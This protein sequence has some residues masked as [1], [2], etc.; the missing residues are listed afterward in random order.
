MKTNAKL[1]TTLILDC[2]ERDVTRVA[3]VRGDDIT[4]LEENARAQEVQTLTKKLLKAQKVSLTQLDRIA[5]AVQPG[6]LTGV[7][8]GV[9]AANTMAWLLQK[10][11]VELTEPKFEAA[12]GQLL[13]TKTERKLA[14]VRD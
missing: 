6:S 5:V 11:I 1:V 14:R 2:S 13:K 3:L 9:V 4:Y 10:P 12:L 7:R 8:I